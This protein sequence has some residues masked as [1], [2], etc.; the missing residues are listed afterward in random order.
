MLS[1]AVRYIRRWNLDGSRACVAKVERTEM[2]MKRW[3]RGRSL[4]DRIES[5]G[6]DSIENVRRTRLDDGVKR[7]MV[8]EG[9]KTKGK[10]GFGWLWERWHGDVVQGRERWHGDVVQDRERWHGDVVQGRERWHGDVVQVRE[11]W[12]ENNWGSS[13]KQSWNDDWDACVSAEWG[14]ENPFQT[15][16]NTQMCKLTHASSWGLGPARQSWSSRCASLLHSSE[17]VGFETRQNRI[18]SDLGAI[19]AKI[20]N[21][22]RAAV[23]VLE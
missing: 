18:Q 17:Q 12:R 7:F 2:R 23:L 15:R 5:P 8:L 9:R 22:N 6:F 16:S 10:T 14:C 11:R 4:K 20:C 19:F 13:G 21:I 1:E 3:V